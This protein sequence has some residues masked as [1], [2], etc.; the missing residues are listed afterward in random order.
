MVRSGAI[1]GTAG[2]VSFWKKPVLSLKNVAVA[3][4]GVPSCSVTWGPTAMN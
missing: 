1:P 3:R 2:L 4:T